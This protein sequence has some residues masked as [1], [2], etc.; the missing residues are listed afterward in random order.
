MSSS[1]KACKY[2]EEID[3][4]KRCLNNSHLEEALN[5]MA[6]SKQCLINDLHQTIFVND[7]LSRKLDRQRH[8]FT[9]ENELLKLE[10]ERLRL[11]LQSIQRSLHVS[12]R[13]LARHTRGCAAT[14]IRMGAM[15]LR[16]RST[17]RQYKRRWNSYQQMCLQFAAYI[18][19]QNCYMVDAVEAKLSN[20]SITACHRQYLELLTR[21]SQL[22]HENM[23][24]RLLAS[25]RRDEHQP[26]SDRIGGGGVVGTSEEERG[27]SGSDETVFRTYI[28]GPR[29]QRCQSV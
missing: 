23:N 18:R 29:K 4:L 27:T 9:E 11:Y 17:K 12:T 22:L 25:N 24:L 14:R 28:K 19:E 13:K 1:D 6:L 15:F 3:N 7:K 21:C 8:Y 20:E 26:R 16:M 5:E 10:M 2:K